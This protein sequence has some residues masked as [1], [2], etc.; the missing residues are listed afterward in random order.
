MDIWEAHAAGLQAQQHSRLSKAL[1][2]LAEA[3]DELDKAVAAPAAGETRTARLF[4]PFLEAE[5]CPSWPAVR[6]A[7]E[8]LFGKT[9][10]SRVNGVEGGKRGVTIVVM[11]L[12]RTVGF[13]GDLWGFKRWTCNLDSAVTTVEEQALARLA[14][15]NDPFAAI[16]SR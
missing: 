11:V 5:T 4:P 15:E 13:E 10:E 1:Q 6:E 8:D 7:L 2:S 12:K 3:V 14:A 16:L 9:E